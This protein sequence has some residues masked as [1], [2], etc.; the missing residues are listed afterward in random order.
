VTVAV[1]ATVGETCVSDVSGE[2]GGQHWTLSKSPYC[3]S[4]DLSIA[5]GTRLVVAPGVEVVFQGH[6]KVDVKGGLTAQGTPSQRIVLTAA[7]TDTGWA[8]LRFWNSNGHTVDDVDQWIEHVELS[9]GKVRGPDT[10]GSY[11]NLRGGCVYAV[12]LADAAKFHFNDNYVHHCSSTYEQLP[13]HGGAFFWAGSH[14][15]T[16]RGNVWED[17]F[18]V[19][20]GGAIGVVHSVGVRIEGGSFSR[21]QAGTRGGAARVFDGDLTVDGAILGA[22]ADANTPNDFT[23]NVTY[24]PPE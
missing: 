15:L 20:E 21:N 23:S 12:D 1:T 10:P 11:Y 8:G 9:F 16:M 24:L 14:F 3:V 6:Y 22:G 18:A 13:S 7:D 19:G 2:V 17:N 4:G 5:S